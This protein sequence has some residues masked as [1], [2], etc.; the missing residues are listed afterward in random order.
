MRDRER[1]AYRRGIW[2]L[3]KAARGAAFGLA[4]LAATPLLRAGAA[5]ARLIV[6]KQTA[7]P[8]ETVWAGVDLRMAPEW[9]TYWRNPGE[10]GLATKIEWKLPAG[11]SAGSI[12]WPP[13]EIH[14]AAGMTTY[15]YHNEVVLLVPLK[16][17]PDAKPGE[18]KIEAHVSWLECKESCVPGEADAGASFRVGGVSEPSPEAKLIAAWLEKVP[19]PDPKLRSLARWGGAIDKDT[20]ELIVEGRALPGFRPDDFLSYEADDYE[21]SP[22]VL[23]LEAPEGGWAFKKRA[24]KFGDAFPERIPGILIQTGEGKILKAVEAILEPGRFRAAAGAPPSAEP[25]AAAVSHPREAQAP[26]PAPARRSL[27]L[28]LFFAFLG[29]AILNV[30]PCVLPVIALKILGFVQQSRENPRRVRQLGVVYALG[31]LTAFAFLAGM[32]LSIQHARGVAGWG[33]QMQSVSYRLALLVIVVLV[34]L[35]LF[36][37]FEVQLGGRASAAAS[38][39]ASKEG[40][41]GAFFNGLLATALA[42]PCTAPFLA[43]ALGYAFVQPPAM[44]VL[45]FLT[46]GL[47]LAA[48][49]VILSWNPGWLRFLPKPGPWMNRFRTAMGFPMMGAAIWLF[50]FTAP[51]FGEGG[52]LWL[53][54]FLLVLALAAWVWGEFAQR[55]RRRGAVAVALLLLVADYGWILE[56]RLHWRVP[57][58]RSRQT[59]P[60][61]EKPGGILWR[62]WS[63]EAVEAA[64]REGHPVLVDF[65]AR[66]CLT[67]QANEKLAIETPAVRKKLEEIGAV[68]FRADNTDPNPAIDRELRKRGRA[69]VPLALVFPADTNAPPIVLPTVLTERIV[70]N[71][72]DQAAAQK[73]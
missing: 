35:N 11:V 43:P 15:V 62:A 22:G 66:W 59:N 51:S 4:L 40:A 20:A 3:R 72:L 10:S 34:A 17:A 73:R 42:T 65:T 16:I 68:A 50:D 21:V 64:R 49:Y 33:A 60:R 46:A 52:I 39:L 57:Q 36:G 70:L 29:G 54:M 55:G 24:M 6:D 27:L 23:P 25:A 14:E 13:P 31:V 63:P 47:G 1:F 45:M 7:R 56:G 2:S 19:R 5:Q 58:G 41:A 32:I 71:A 8:G 37:V 44:V 30:M 48:P 9:H 28:M 53:G 67:C 38:R 69:G 61:R 18:V 12:Y 26:A